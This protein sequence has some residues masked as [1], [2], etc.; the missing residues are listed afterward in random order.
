M[1]FFEEIMIEVYVNG[2]TAKVLRL[3]LNE[4]QLGL[5]VLEGYFWTGHVACIIRQIKKYII[6][7]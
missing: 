7:R 2:T 5:R 1:H 4:N 3:N 6:K